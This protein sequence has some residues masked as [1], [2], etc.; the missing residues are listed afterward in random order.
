MMSLMVHLVVLGIPLEV[1]GLRMGS[2]GL[3]GLS[4]VTE[5]VLEVLQ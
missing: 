2:K 4:V 1:G 3:E 5:S